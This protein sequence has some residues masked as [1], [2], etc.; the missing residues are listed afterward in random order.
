M[1]IDNLSQFGLSIQVKCRDF[2]GNPG[3]PAQSENDRMRGP[4][5]TLTESCEPIEI[6]SVTMSLPESN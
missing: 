1:K 2:V 6:V 5:H 4:I 3:A